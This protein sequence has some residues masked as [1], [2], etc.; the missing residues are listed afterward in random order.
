MKPELIREIVFRVAIV[1]D[2]DLVKHCVIKR[3]EVR[4]TGRRLKWDV[5]CND[6]DRVRCVW[7]SERVNVGIVR[8]RILADERRLTVTGGFPRQHRE[9]HDQQRCQSNYRNSFHD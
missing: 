2:V 7:A 6:G 1:I 5:V 4:S 3:W 9:A 8:H